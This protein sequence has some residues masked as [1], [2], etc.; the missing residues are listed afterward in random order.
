MLCSQWRHYLFYKPRF[1]LFWTV[2]I[3]QRPGFIGSLSLVMPCLVC[4]LWCLG[5]HR[6]VQWMRRIPLA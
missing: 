4:S 5:G 2:V 6:E 3:V 1:V